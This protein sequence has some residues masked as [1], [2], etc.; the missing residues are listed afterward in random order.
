MRLQL[1]WCGM[2]FLACKGRNWVINDMDKLLLFAVVLVIGEPVMLK[3]IQVLDQV[4]LLDLR[5]TV[6]IHLSI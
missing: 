2:N 5:E 4:T 3:F 1:R 6:G